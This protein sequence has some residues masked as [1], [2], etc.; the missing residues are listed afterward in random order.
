MFKRIKFK[1]LYHLINSSLF[2]GTHL[3]KT[4]VKILNSMGFNVHYDVKIVGPI[5]L[6]NIN[7]LTIKKGCWI[8]KNFEIL[9]NGS[10]TIEENCDIGPYVTFFTGSHEISDLNRRAGKGLTYNYKVGSGTWIG[11]KVNIGS[12][13][14]IGSGVVIGMDS[15][16]IKDCKEN[17]LYFG[18]PAFKVKDIL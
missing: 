11:G 1:F 6:N 7:S 16:I 12:G 4:K 18:S 8:G 9:G 2:R 17:S 10:V 15:L 13:A 14:Q 5:F 3:F